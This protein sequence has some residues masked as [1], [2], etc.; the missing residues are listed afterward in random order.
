MGNALRGEVGFDADGAS[1]TLIYSVNALCVLESELGSG[2]GKIA[3]TMTDLDSLK[4]ADI[5][6]LFWAGLHDHHPAIDKLEAGRI[7]TT[8]GLPQ[9]MVLISKAF[10]FAFGEEGKGRPL[11]D[12]KSRSAGNGKSSSS[13]GLS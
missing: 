5:R 3:A 6:T 13:I 1:Y 4:L 12:P 9:A 11:G 2:V 10:N 8:I 7:M